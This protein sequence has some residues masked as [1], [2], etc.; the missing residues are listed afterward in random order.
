MIPSTFV[1]LFLSPWAAFSFTRPILVSQLERGELP[2]GL[3]P[4]EPVGREAL[5]G[6][7][8]GEYE[9]LPFLLSLLS[10]FHISI[11]TE[12]FLSCETVFIPLESLHV[13]LCIHSGCLPQVRKGPSLPRRVWLQDFFA[14]SHLLSTSPSAKGHCLRSSFHP[15]HVETFYF[16]ISLFLQR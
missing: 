11:C 8:P 7:C 13:M 15:C 2:W 5:R 9:T 16:S 4:W 12:C 10:C 3:D 14:C 6:V 1:F